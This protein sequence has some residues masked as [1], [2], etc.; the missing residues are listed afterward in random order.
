MG[1]PLDFPLDQHRDAGYRP[2]FRTEVAPP[3]T[4]HRLGATQGAVRPLDPGPDRGTP[5]AD[6]LMR[7]VR[8]ICCDGPIHFLSDY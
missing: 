8:G 7:R 1:H 3:D 5:L 2:F 6:A 4:S